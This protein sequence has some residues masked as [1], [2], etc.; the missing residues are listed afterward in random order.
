MKQIHILTLFVILIT[1]CSYSKQFFNTKKDL[2]MAFKSVYR[3]PGLPELSDSEESNMDNLTNEIQSKVENEAKKPYLPNKHKIFASDWLSISSIGFK[4]N[5][6]YPLI[7]TPSGQ[8]VIIVDDKNT[9]IN[10][11]FKKGSV[12]AKTSF[13]FRLTSTYIYYN[14]L[15]SDINILGALP[16]KSVS[17]CWTIEN[18]KECFKVLD[19]NKTTWTLCG[20]DNKVSTKWSCWIQKLAKLPIDEHCPFKDRNANLG[21][22]I[23]TKTITQPF[24]II[25]I[26]SKHCNQDWNYEKKGGDWECD[27]KEGKEQSPIDLPPP[28]MAIDSPAKPIFEYEV[29]DGKIPVDFSGMKEGDVITVKYEK[30]ALRIKHPNFGRIVTPDGAVYRAQEIVFHTPSEHTIEGERADLEMQVI[31][32]GQTKG[33]IAKHVILSI[34]FRNQ[35]G[36]YNKFFEKLDVYNLPSPLDKE[37]EVKNSLYVPH[38]FY[39]N[40]DDDM[41]LVPPMSFFTYQGSLVEP[42][43][44][45]RTIH[46]V[47]SKPIPLS[48]TTIT[49]MREALRPPDLMDTKGNVKFNTKIYKNYRVINQLNGRAVFHYDH[50]KYNCPDFR[51]N[52]PK[53]PPKSHYEKVIKQSTKYFF[54]P[55]FKPS[56]IPDAYVVPVKE[57]LENM[58]G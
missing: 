15:K 43:C 56:G 36:H 49:L 42:P 27:C 39:S 2:D 18:K 30:F 14:S 23:I 20:K 40:T 34:L 33:D 29:V 6:K 50:T 11:K 45:E 46:Y 21:G 25:P 58:S 4:N 57:A 55:G 41:I 54:V 28:Q 26:P 32:Y 8:Q 16:I 19:K 9:R 1:L 37:R 10:K 24:I 48:N 51:K 5:Q 22:K 13:Y 47:I 38:V 44:S 7:N 31:H 35:P 3:T 17:Q 53:I 12:P 52:K